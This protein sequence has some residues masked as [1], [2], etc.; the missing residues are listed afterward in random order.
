G[1]KVRRAAPTFA[2]ESPAQWVK[3]LS[4]PNSWHRETAQRLLV[5]RRDLSVVPALKKVAL[6]GKNPLGRVRALW[7]LEGLNALDLFTVEKA[8]HDKDPKVRAAAIRV[9]E[10]A[11]NSEDGAEITA[12]LLTLTNETSPEVQL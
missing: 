5:E 9:S 2:K 7:T 8:F 11:L 4:H 6:E 3:S 10:P 12:H 1:K